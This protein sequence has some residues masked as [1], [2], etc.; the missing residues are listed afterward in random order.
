[1]KINCKAAGFVLLEA[2]RETPG[3]IATVERYHAPLRLAFERITME[4]G[5][6]TSDG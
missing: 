2:P 3:Y 1:M 6:E 4:V 5:R